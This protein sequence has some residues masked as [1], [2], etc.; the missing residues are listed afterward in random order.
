MSPLSS[1]FPTPLGDCRDLQ[2]PAPGTPVPTLLPNRSQIAYT[3]YKNLYF[4]Y[5][6]LAVAT[7]LAIMP[8]KGL[9]G[10]SAQKNISH[11]E[12]TFSRSVSL[13]FD[14]CH[15]THDSAVITPSNRTKSILLLALSVCAIFNDFLYTF[16]W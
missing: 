9:D 1:P 15:T 5:R 7:P 8:G 10:V 4:L 2:G 16:W 3:P 13:V 14:L 11:Y 12:L 6:L